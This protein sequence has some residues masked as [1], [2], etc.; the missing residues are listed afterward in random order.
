M[1]RPA[2]TE[3]QRDEVDALKR[4]QIVT[5]LAVCIG[6]KGYAAT[7]IADIASAAKVSKSTVYAH[8]ADKEDAFLAMYSMA[9]DEVIK[10]L[11]RA[12][13]EAADLPWRE[14]LRAVLGAY[15]SAL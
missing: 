15:L 11:R 3:A 10:M 12:D 4:W 9:N 8:F 1:P 13:D 5:G 14:R 6:A 7:T 2:F